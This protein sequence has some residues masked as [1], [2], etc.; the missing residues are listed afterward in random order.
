MPIKIFSVEEMVAAEKAADA[1]GVTYDR[2]METAGRRLVEAI[3]D[4]HA[5]AGMDVLILVG[6]GN[7]GGDGL[8]AARHLAAAG[9]AVICYLYRERDPAEDVNLAAAKTVGVHTAVA[10]QDSEYRQLHRCLQTADLVLDALLGTGVDRPIGGELARMMRAVHAGLATRR[11]ALA[12]QERPALLSVAHPDAAPPDRPTIVAVDCPSGLNCDT[13]ALDD[14]AIPAHLTV[15]FA[16][17]KRGHFRFPGA[18]A[19]GELV[20]ADIGVPAALPA[21]AEVE[22]TL[23]TAETVR[24]ML[25]ER[26]LQGHKGTFGWVLIAAGSADYWGAPLLAGRGA[27]RAGAGL[28]ALAVPD[29]IRS[30]V[31][32]Q[33]PEATYPPIT[34]Q[35]KLSTDA[36]R[37]LLKTADTYKAM[38]IG[39]GLGD[40]AE[41][42]SIL[43][44]EEGGPPT[45]PPLVIDADGL[46][47]LAGMENWAERLPSRTVLT[48]HPGEMA[49]LMAAASIAEVQERERVVVAQEQAAA[50]GHVV[51]LK[52]AHTVVADPDGRCHLIPFANPILGTAGS[53][54]VLAGVIAALLGQGAE[55]YEA[56]VAGVYLHGAAGERAGKKLGNAGLLAAEI[57]DHIPPFR[58][59]ITGTI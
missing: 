18:A 48:P 6:P 32:A 56:A 28:V 38:L 21:V 15:T 4:R 59:Q 5:V 17:P 40:A 9:A 27:Y 33:L 49:R 3:M 44:K 46:N 47:V 34:E 2:M 35:G 43:F 50:W 20:V 22:L 26:P 12:R 55:P 31:A 24:E 1:A 25:P 45:L 16:G 51:V 7:N 39:P 23:A 52:G 13:G 8:V 54:D 37:L 58:A 36:A 30:T 14:L 42:M 19:C 53:G 41:F 57:A 11:D 10:P 29:A